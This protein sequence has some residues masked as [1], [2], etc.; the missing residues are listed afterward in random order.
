MQKLVIGHLQGKGGK[1]M[2]LFRSFENLICLLS[3]I[4]S[5]VSF[6][7]KLFLLETVA[8]YSYFNASAF[9]VLL[10]RRT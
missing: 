5:P 6:E 1:G 3:D 10:K 9:L 8:L 2:E 7:K 4:H